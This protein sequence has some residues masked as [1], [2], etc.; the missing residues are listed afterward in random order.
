M[1]ARGSILERFLGD[2]ALTLATT[3][4]DA[5]AVELAKIPL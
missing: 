3:D 1:F 5:V 4:L 2:D